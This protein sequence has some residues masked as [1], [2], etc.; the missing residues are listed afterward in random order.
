MFRRRG[1]RFLGVGGSVRRRRRRSLRGLGPVKID[2]AMRFVV[3]EHE[4]VGILVGHIPSAICVISQVELE[5]RENLR[6]NECNGG[7][8]TS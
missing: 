5:V 1:D 7:R 8:V 2:D 6:S 3:G 4:S